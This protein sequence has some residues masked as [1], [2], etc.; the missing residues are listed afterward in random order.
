MYIGCALDNC[1]IR[2][3]LRSEHVAP[4]VLVERV[5]GDVESR[6]VPLHLLWLLLLQMMSVDGPRLTGAATKTDPGKCDDHC[7]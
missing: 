7:K 4:Y 3:L 5:D 1:E 6:V 2:R